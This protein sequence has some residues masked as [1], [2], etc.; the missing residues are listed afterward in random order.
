MMGYH[1]LSAAGGR[2]VSTQDRAVRGDRDAQPEGYEGGEAAAIGGVQVEPM[3][4]RAMQR[5]WV[6]RKANGGGSA[7]AAAIPGGPGAPLG[8][9]V[10]SRMERTLG[11]DLSGVRV[12]TSGDSA[13]A[14]EG[15]GARAFTVGS[16]V[17]FGRGEF[18][19][20]SREGDRL[21]AH[22]LTHVVQ[23]QKSGVQR[24]AAPDGEGGGGEHGDHEAGGHEVSEPGD[25]SEKEA[26]AM[27][28]HAADA[29]HGG[30]DKGG[31]EHGAAGGG[32]KVAAEKPQ[33]AAAAPSVG[34]KIF[35]ANKPGA[36]PA[37]TTTAPASTSSTKPGA[38]ASKDAPTKPPEEI[39]KEKQIADM[40]ASLTALNAGD[41]QLATRLSLAL[42]SIDKDVAKFPKN[43]AVKAYKTFLDTKKQQVVDKCQEEVA[44][45]LAALDGVDEKNPASAEKL[46]SLKKSPALEKWT[47]NSI[48]G[49]YAKDKHPRLELFNKAIDK[50]IAAN[51][52]AIEKQKQHEK[53]EQEK[54]K[55]H[56]ADASASSGAPGS[57]THPA[58]AGGHKS[59]PAS[60]SA[61]ADSTKAAPK[62]TASATATSAEAKPSVAAG[63]PTTSATPPAH[64]STP[65][66]TVTAAP[67]TTHGAGPDAHEGA[68]AST[69]AKSSAT[70]VAAPPA[71]DTHAPA[72][73]AAQPATPNAT[74]SPTTASSANTTVGQAPTDPAA[75]AKKQ[76]LTLKKQVAIA[77][78]KTALAAAEDKSKIFGAALEGVNIAL[79]LGKGFLAQHG[80]ELPEDVVARMKDTIALL[81][82]NKVTQK[83]LDALFAVAEIQSI[84]T[85]D[86]IDQLF[87]DADAVSLGSN[88]RFLSKKL[89][90]EDA[91]KAEALALMKSKGGG[92]KSHAG[93]EA[94]HSKKHGDEGDERKASDQGEAPKGAVEAHG[95]ES[96][97]EKDDKD[98]KPDGKKKKGMKSKLKHATEEVYEKGV[99]APFEAEDKLEETRPDFK[100]AAEQ[101]APALDE[102]KTGFAL[103]EAIRFHVKDLK[104]AKQS[105]QEAEQALDAFLADHGGK[106]VPN[107]NA[108]K[109]PLVQ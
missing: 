20:G 51:K 70:A 86:E 82:K 76:E 105:Q 27:G 108:P 103:L 52:D 97:G 48:C 10:Q 94:D 19:P 5:R 53:E 65:T 68:S 62:A 22:E 50:K 74:A 32:K 14:A 69:S 6:Q 59:A 42:Q 89:T 18:A 38:P 37:K 77:R 56:A 9:G 11:A 49:F 63:A 75:E 47:R 96:G 24:K 28:D 4:L 43:E 101:F 81:A 46:E 104:A 23:G 21:L 58:D 55:A 99:K 3:R 71:H 60:S 85:V 100:V 36:G 98:K 26:D 73:P 78:V 92:D 35:R 29:L 72:T 83:Q 67:P 61:P 2:R 79:T 16:D 80:I 25:A 106:A 95:P 31:G 34:R 30:G 39:A 93:K 102:A 41:P 64:A 90:Q 40:T 15:M 13:E 88:L 54:K 33:V 45:L 8:G 109:A 87:A 84:E 12:H 1:D 107:Q 7:A 44:P 66:A 91:L 17:H 57:H